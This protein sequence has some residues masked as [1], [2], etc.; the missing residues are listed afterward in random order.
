MLNINS[1]NKHFSELQIFMS[2]QIL[3]VLAI[4]ETKLDCRTRDQE[5]DL[6]GYVCLRKD[7]DSR[8]GG[9]CVYLKEYLQYSRKTCFEIEDL[10]MISVEIKRPKSSPFLFTTWYRPR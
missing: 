7:R 10:E 4:N 9:V 2:N 8:G 5:L 6:P 3:D 1:L